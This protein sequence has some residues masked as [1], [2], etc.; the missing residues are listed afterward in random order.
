MKELIDWHRNV[1]ILFPV[2]NCSYSAVF[3]IE[4]RS[5]SKWKIRLG[6]L[7]RVMSYPSIAGTGNFTSLFLSSSKHD[8]IIPS[9][10][11]K[12]NGITN[13]LYLSDCSLNLW[14]LC[15]LSDP[16]LR[17]KFRNLIYWLADFLTSWIPDDRIF[18]LSEFCLLNLHTSLLNF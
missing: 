13:D 15:R 11:S 2:E 18:R 14:K 3:Q 6:S 17:P 16:S 5:E 10:E 9:T 7:I 4:C 12:M 1:T 8:L